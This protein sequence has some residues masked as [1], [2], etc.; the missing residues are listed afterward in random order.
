M[1]SPELLVSPELS[2]S[3]FGEWQRRPDSSALEIYDR[4][5]DLMD[6]DLDALETMLRNDGYPFYHP[7]GEL[8]HRH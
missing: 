6:C 3:Q 4:D 8:R 1:V 2:N 7:F 5:E